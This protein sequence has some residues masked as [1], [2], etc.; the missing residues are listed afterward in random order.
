MFIDYYFRNTE[1]QTRRAA[2]LEILR[3]ICRYYDCFAP[4]LEQ[5][6]HNFQGETGNIKS[7]CTILN[8]TIDGSSKGF[9]DVDGCTQLFV[10]Q[11]IIDY[12]YQNIAKKSLFEVY[13]WMTKNE[14]SLIESKFDKIHITILL[15]FLFYFRIYIPKDELTSIVKFLTSIKTQNKQLRKVIYLTLNGFLIMKHGDFNY[16]K[17]METFFVGDRAADIATDVLRVIYDGTVC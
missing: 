2:A 10:N 3:V 4:F 7:L 16:Y 6:L 14:Q 9:R 11:N 5:Q 8:F 15:R 13:D 1:L 12:T 17:N